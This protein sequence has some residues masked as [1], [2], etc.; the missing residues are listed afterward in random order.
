MVKC[1]H[2]KEKVFWVWFIHTVSDIIIVQ[3]LMIIRF[4]YT[5]TTNDFTLVKYLIWI[6]FINKFAIRSFQ[7]VSQ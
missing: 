2:I 6:S 1:K 5:K 7:E 4:Y 3:L